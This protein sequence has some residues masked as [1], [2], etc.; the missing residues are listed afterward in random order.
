MESLRQ[1]RYPACSEQQM[2]PARVTLA[3]GA[4]LIFAAMAV[5]LIAMVVVVAMVVAA[6][7][8]HGR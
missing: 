5:V 4:L 2:R 6:Y 1:R 8:R 7:D 3:T